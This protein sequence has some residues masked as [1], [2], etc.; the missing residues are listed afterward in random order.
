MGQ[1][2]LPVLRVH[3]LLGMNCNLQGIMS[4]YAISHSFR[5]AAVKLA[6]T[7]GNPYK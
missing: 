6:I 7:L 5:P 3:F 4:P 2:K 1:G